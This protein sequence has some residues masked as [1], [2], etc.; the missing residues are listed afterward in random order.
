MI[1]IID[2]HYWQVEVEDFGRRPTNKYDISALLYLIE[3]CKK[4]I[5][6]I[7]TWY[8]KTT[9]EIASRFPKKI[10]YTLDYMEE[11]LAISKHELKTRCKTKEDIG[12]YTSELG[13]VF[14]IYA[15]S[16]TYDFNLFKEVDFFFIDGNHGFDE[17]RIDSVKA[18]TYL[19][20][21][22]G[23]TIA[24]H[25]VHTKNLTQVPN[26]MQ[27]LSKTQDIYYLKN[28]NIGFI[29]VS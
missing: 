16:Q 9:Y 20:K 11:D 10:I 24:W 26:Y 4:N 13:N 19:M 22:D 14:L 12:K 28:S 29:K 5:V 8:G 17:V 2:P 7:G 27:H 23:G 18:I 25:D 1:K 6:E 3:S 15:N 21:N